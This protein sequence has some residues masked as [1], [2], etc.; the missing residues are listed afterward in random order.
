MRGG[1]YNDDTTHTL[2]KW[3]SRS[4]HKSVGISGETP[5]LD[6]SNHRYQHHQEEYG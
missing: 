6:F 3:K 5:I 4:L 1:V 2:N